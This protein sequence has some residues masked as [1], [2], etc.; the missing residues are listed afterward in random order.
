MSL[1]LAIAVAGYASSS[2]QQEHAYFYHHPWGG[3]ALGAIFLYQFQFLDILPLYCLFLIAV[4]FA[5][6][7]FRRHRNWT[8]LVPSAAFWGSRNL[9]FQICRPIPC[10]SL[11]LISRNPG[12]AGAWDVRQGRVCYL[13]AGVRDHPMFGRTLLAGTLT[14][15]LRR[16][17]SVRGLGQWS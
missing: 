12:V 2:F 13:C 17:W 4:P 9:G 6:V 7:Q 16:V 11:Q 10:H 1:F 3:T 8:V 14:G 15:R 5:I